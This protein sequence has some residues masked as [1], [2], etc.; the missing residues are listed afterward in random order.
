[1]GL[2]IYG[3]D[4]VKFLLSPGLACQAALEKTEVKLELSADIDMLLALEK[5]IRGR[6]YHAIQRY[7]KVHNK[8]LKDY[9]KK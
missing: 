7:S 4:P 1:M 5:S 9:D 3:L 8:Y 2:K 6:R